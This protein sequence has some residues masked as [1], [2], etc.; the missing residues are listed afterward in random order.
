M[1]ICSDALE[2]L[3]TLPTGLCRCCVT[4]PPYYNLRNYGNTPGQIGLEGT[5]D[6]YIAKLRDVFYE[7]K[8]VL[9]DDGT[10]WLNIAD[11]YAG[12]MK[13]S[14]FSADKN[15]GSKEAGRKGMLSLQGLPSVKF[16]LPRKNLLGIPW[17]LAFALQD[18]GWV[19]R[20]DIIWDKTN[21]MPESVKD[22][23]TRSHEYIF[24]FAK[25]PHYFYDYAAIAEPVAQSTVRRT[26][27]NVEAQHGSDRGYRNMKA[28]GGSIAAFGAP[29]SRR[30]SGN[31]ERK[32]RPFPGAKE[33]GYAGSVPYEYITMLRNKRDVWHMSVS[34][35]RGINHF[36]VFP[37]ELAENCI[38]AASAPGDMVLDPFVGSGTTVRVAHRLGRR[39]IGIDISQEYCEEAERVKA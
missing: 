7:V 1:I 28:V 18:D 23:C 14:R 31:K 5:V 16:Q 2:A 15:A 21:C 19:L 25:Q 29:Q 13:G 11:C 26:N 9:T 17:K 38:L 8:R 12:S 4:S 35:R 32:T 34:K 22:R 37:E 39:A 6:E 27:Q 30:R 36:A 20:Q 3:K 10:L 33:N 24:L